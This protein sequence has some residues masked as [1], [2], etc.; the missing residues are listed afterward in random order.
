M[1]SHFILL[2]K[3]DSVPEN[4]FT[5]LLDLS[6]NPSNRLRKTL[7]VQ[8]LSKSNISKNQNSTCTQRAR[9]PPS[10]TGSVL[11]APAITLVQGPGNLSSRVVTLQGL[12]KRGK[13]PL[14]LATG[15]SALSHIRWLKS[16]CQK[17]VTP[18]FQ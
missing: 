16:A 14:N 5:R 13:T 9:L 4:H 3:L 6:L 10:K 12:Q 7:P 1:L 2:I 11:I 8:M 18:S 17:E 15:C